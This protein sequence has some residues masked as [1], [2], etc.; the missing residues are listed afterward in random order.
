MSLQVEFAKMVVFYVISTLLC[1][2][3]VAETPRCWCFSLMRW[4]A[5]PEDARAFSCGVMAACACLSCGRRWLRVGGRVLSDDGS[6]RN[7]VW[8]ESGMGVG[9]EEIKKDA[10]ERKRGALH[11]K[12]CSLPPPASH[13]PTVGDIDPGGAVNGRAP[14]KVSAVSIV[15]ETNPLVPQAQWVCHNLELLKQ[16]LPLRLSLPP[17]PAIH[18]QFIP[19]F[20]SEATDMTWDSWWVHRRQQRKVCLTFICKYHLPLSQFSLD[21]SSLVMSLFLLGKDSPVA[22][23]H[24]APFIKQSH[25]LDLLNAC[26]K[27]GLHL[28]FSWRHK[29]RISLPLSRFPSPHT[30]Y[31]NLSH[32]K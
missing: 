32:L 30:V 13:S 3:H 2:L 27:V 29:E 9:E 11:N 4:A 22:P 5:H 21:V 31:D 19:A 8:D 23:N 18:M 20:H 1:L 10:K 6:W 24:K 25:N 12:Q 14:W 26:L 16:M 15:R 7:H 17:P 28:R